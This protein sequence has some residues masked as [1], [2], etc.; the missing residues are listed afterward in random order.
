MVS[1]VLKVENARLGIAC[2]IRLAVFEWGAM[3]RMGLKAMV[4]VGCSVVGVWIVGSR[5]LEDWGECVLMDGEN[6]WK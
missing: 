1:P 3:R 4:V 6:T 5:I 2:W